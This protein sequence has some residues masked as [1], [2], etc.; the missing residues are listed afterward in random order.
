MSYIRHRMARPLRMEVDSDVI[1]T[2]GMTHKIRITL[3][4][5]K[6]GWS[7]GHPAIVIFCR[8]CRQAGFSFLGVEFV[9]GPHNQ[10]HSDHGSD[11]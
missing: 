9:H 8:Y 10:F 4:K 1:M 3:I 2:I 7:E 5:H 6:L 11:D